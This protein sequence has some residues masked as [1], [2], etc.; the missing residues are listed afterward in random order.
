MGAPLTYTEGPGA[1]DWNFWDTHI[2]DVF[3][4]LL[5]DRTRKDSTVIMG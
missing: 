5:Q 2:Q 1:H 4:W 3:D